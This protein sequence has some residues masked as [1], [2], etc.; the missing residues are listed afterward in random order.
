M[1][2]LRYKEQYKPSIPTHICRNWSLLILIS[3]SWTFG[4]LLANLM[5]R[6]YALC[7]LDS[8]VIYALVFLLI[9]K[10][11]NVLVFYIFLPPYSHFS[12]ICIPLVNKPFRVVCFACVY[13]PLS[14]IYR[15][16]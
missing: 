10:I 2:L 9:I 8:R 3:V 14:L 6:V 13:Q 5:L 15:A 11:A 12:P 4:L 7:E 1:V 16:R